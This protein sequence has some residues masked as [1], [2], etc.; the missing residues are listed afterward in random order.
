MNA[1]YYV[2]TTITTIGY[3]D[4][5][6]VTPVEKAYIVLLE[7]IGILLFTT[8]QQ[9]SGSIVHVKTRKEV[10]KEVY[11]DGIDFVFQIDMAFDGDLKDEIYEQVA[12]Y[13]LL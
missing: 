13:Q 3:G 2:T 10:N 9:R 12:E 8:I 6:G 1:W 5:Y 4:I 11:D 7:F